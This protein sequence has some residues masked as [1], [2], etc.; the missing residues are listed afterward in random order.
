M[1][2]P[3][4]QT[5]HPGVS[6][7]SRKKEPEKHSD[8]CHRGLFISFKPDKC[9]W[10][11]DEILRERIPAVYFFQICGSDS[12]KPGSPVYRHPRKN[13]EI[14]PGAKGLFF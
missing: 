10:L 7:F 2:N 9:I 5:N 12:V 11:M 4:N 3:F 13:A 8:F 1:Q 14:I 6:S